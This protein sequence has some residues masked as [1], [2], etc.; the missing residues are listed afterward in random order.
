MCF[1][2]LAVTNANGLPQRNQPSSCSEVVSGQLQTCLMQI[3]L[4]T[5]SERWY[6]LALVGTYS[7][8]QARQQCLTQPLQMLGPQLQLNRLQASRN[9]ML[10]C[11]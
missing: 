10:L 9:G 3:R 8:T 5:L 2:I 4:L 7:W 1:H 11:M 6:S